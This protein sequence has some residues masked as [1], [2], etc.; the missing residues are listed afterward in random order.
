MYAIQVSSFSSI[1]EGRGI[2]D[3]MWVTP[4]YE[5]GMG[6]VTSLS[7]SV[8]IDEVKAENGGVMGRA[9]VG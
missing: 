5:G 7:C 2:D 3:C 4:W 6:V 9:T 1:S 8:A